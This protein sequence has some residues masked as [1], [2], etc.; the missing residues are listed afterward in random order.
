[1]RRAVLLTLAL[2][3]IVGSPGVA[4]ADV[5]QV[6]GYSYVSNNADCAWVQTTIRND[7]AQPHLDSVG[8]M[9]WFG[10]G[11]RC[12]R[13][14]FAPAGSI[15]VAQDLI[16][17]DWQTQSILVCSWGPWVWSGPNTHEVWTGFGWGGRPCPGGNWYAGWG[18]SMTNGHSTWFYQTPWIWLG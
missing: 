14:A 13:I 15:A 9:D 2:A 12:G 5:Q 10:N 3:F 1:M 17:W 11:R 18:Q 6:S 16:Y 8:T 7:W 4:V